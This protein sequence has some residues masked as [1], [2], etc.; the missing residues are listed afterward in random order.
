M[1]LWV[2]AQQRNKCHN[3]ATALT[4]VYCVHYMHNSAGAR[5]Q[6]VKLKSDISVW[7]NNL[8]HPNPSEPKLASRVKT[9]IRLFI[10]I[11]LVYCNCV[12]C[13]NKQK[14]TPWSVSAS[15][16]YRPSDRCLSA[17]WLQTFADRGCHVVSVT[18]TY[19]RILG[20]LDRIRYFFYQVAPQLYSRG[21]VDHVPDPLLFFCLVVPGI[22]PGPPDL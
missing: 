6:T 4:S 11:P 12:N 19:G 15:E 9:A 8:I 18:D 7:I 14:Q 2:H 5:T 20:F 13:T 3:A 10:Y 22:E 16:L 17:K 21:W 1:N